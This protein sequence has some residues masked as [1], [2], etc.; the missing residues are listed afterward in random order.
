VE[1]LRDELGAPST[2]NIMKVADKQGLLNSDGPVTL[3]GW[4]SLVLL[5]GRPANA[6]GMPASLA[7]PVFGK[8]IDALHEVMPSLCPCLSRCRASGRLVLGAFVNITRQ[9]PVQLAAQSVAQS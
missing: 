6:S 8:F 2:V 4:Q 7:H 1:A 9:V 5:S 3:D